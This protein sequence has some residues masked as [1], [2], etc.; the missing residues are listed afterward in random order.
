MVP[1]S[2]QSGHPIKLNKSISESKLFTL[3]DRLTNTIRSA[4]RVYIKK[5]ITLVTDGS[6]IS[7][8]TCVTCSPTY[9]IIFTG[10][11][12]ITI[13]TIWPKGSIS[14]TTTKF[15]CWILLWLVLSRI[16][17]IIIICFTAVTLVPCIARFTNTLASFITWSALTTYWYRIIWNG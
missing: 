17:W 12:S 10:T 7:R 14:I 5:C 15:T 3:L 9:F 13:L 1:A 11:L 8:Y 16:I 2:T 6:N 4:F